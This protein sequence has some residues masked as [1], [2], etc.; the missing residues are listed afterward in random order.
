MIVAKKATSSF[1]LI[2]LFVKTIELIVTL[3]KYGCKFL[4]TAFVEM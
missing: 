2:S 3:C 1:Y 4:F